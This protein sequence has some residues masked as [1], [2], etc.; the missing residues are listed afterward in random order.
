MG[1]IEK[2]LAHMRANPKGDWQI[3]DFKKIARSLKIDWDHDG[4]SHVVFR[5]PDGTHVSVPA[6]KPIKPVYVKKFLSL[7]EKMEENRE[8]A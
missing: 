1:R 5:S 3:G 8:N 4:T 7:V 2:A 6:H